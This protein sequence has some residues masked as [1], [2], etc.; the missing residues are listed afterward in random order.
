M[1][2][3]IVSF[4]ISSVLFL[5]ACNNAAEN[6][7]EGHETADKTTS[8][9][10]RHA[11]AADEA[12][13]KVIAT[14][15][16]DV[17]G[18]VAASVKAIVEAYLEVKNAL[19]AD[20]AADAAKAAASIAVSIKA[21]DKSLLTADQKKVFDA[22]EKGLKSGAEELEKQP[23]D[24]AEQRIQ[25]YGLSLGV[26]ELVKAFGVGRTLYHDHCP[27]ARDNQGAMWI[28]ETKEVKNPYFGAEMLTCGTVEEVISE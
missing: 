4:V 3:T 24:I 2:K 19:V 17:D 7:H 1:K 27:M 25:F 26:Y 11:A 10:T 8:D 23:A 6:K 20:N 13:V 18:Q 9:T 15:F 5:G 16:K 28:S 12:D 21:L 22:A 14:T